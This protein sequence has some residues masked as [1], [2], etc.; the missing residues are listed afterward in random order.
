MSL[1]HASAR[2]CFDTAA[3][4]RCSM[5]KRMSEFVTHWK[6]FQ[7]FRFSNEG[8]ISLYKNPCSRENGGQT[9]GT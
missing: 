7:T 5:A 6:A 8:L 3:A 1:A 2:V 9:E 4:V